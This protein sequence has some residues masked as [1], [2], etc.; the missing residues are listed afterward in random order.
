MSNLD[1]QTRLSCKQYSP[2][3]LSLCQSTGFYVRETIFKTNI[4][5]I[6]DCIAKFRN[7]NWKKLGLLCFSW[8]TNLL[9][10]KT[11]HFCS[12]VK[13]LVDKNI[14]C[15]SILEWPLMQIVGREKLIR[16]R[17]QFLHI[18]IYCLLVHYR[19]LQSN[20]L[21]FSHRSLDR[22]LCISRTS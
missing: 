12:F 20:P 9:F 14:S 2:F 7:Q 8:K 6:R 13:V 11:S 17:C 16:I 21:K 10:S 15:K 22:E 18:H 3:L 4:S 5:G 19:V 1:E